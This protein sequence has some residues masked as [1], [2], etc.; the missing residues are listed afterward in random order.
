MWCS[1][2]FSSG[3]LDKTLKCNVKIIGNECWL[4]Y[5]WVDP[6]PVP[7]TFQVIF[8]WLGNW[9]RTCFF[10]IWDM[11]IG[12]RVSTV[13]LKLLKCMKLWL[14]YILWMKH[15]DSVLDK[16]KYCKGMSNACCDYFLSDWLSDENQ[17]QIDYISSKQISN[18]FS[19]LILLNFSVLINIMHPPNNMKY[20]SDQYSK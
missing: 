16:R 8:N 15:L 18:F 9:S 17:E 1:L 20:N 12:E 6:A 13:A 3:L 4:I 10:L 7:D 11:G 5:R 2:C 19:A 14:L